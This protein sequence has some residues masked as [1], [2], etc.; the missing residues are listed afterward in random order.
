MNFMIVNKISNE[1]PKEI[2]IATNNEGKFVEIEA[3]LKSIN[4]KAVPAFKFNISEP[5]ET[6]LTFQ[7]NSLLKAKYYAKATNLLALADDSGLCVEALN[8]QPGIYSARWALNQNGARDFDFAFTKIYQELQKKAVDFSQDLRA[9]FI[10]NLTIFD[11]KSA[12][13]ISFEGRIDGK[14]KFPAVGNKGFGYD[15]IFIKD[16]MNKTFGEIA[17]DEKDKIS[18]RGVAFAKFLDWLKN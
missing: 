4:I 18:H 12:F 5:E 17:A 16:G 14:L 11:P 13:N 6:G 3:L 9:H 8:N 2:L 1:F 15:P 7:E 10:C